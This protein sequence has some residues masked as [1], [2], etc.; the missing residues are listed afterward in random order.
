MT[1]PSLIAKYKTH[2]TSVK[3]KKF[4]S[5]MSQAILLS[6]NVNG[7]AGDWER[8]FNIR[9]EE[10]NRDTQANVS[11]IKR[12]F[13]KY[14][15]PYLKYDKSFKSENEDVVV[16]LLDGSIFRLWNGGCLV[17]KYDVNGEKHPNKSAY[18]QF[19]FELCP[20]NMQ[21]YYL[22]QKGRSFAPSGLSQAVTR[23][24][25]IESCK[26]YPDY[27]ASLLIIDNWEFKD[28]YPWK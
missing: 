28:D 19:V 6:E 14:L 12:Y 15:A 3:L 7:P 9:D 22:G 20:S 21:E 2:E 10:G 1:M 24:K 4:Y 16:K 11:E 27:C 25:A 17:F 23:E 26:I 13:N 18:D 8:T 5:N